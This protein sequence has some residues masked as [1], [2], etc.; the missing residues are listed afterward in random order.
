V[1]RPPHWGGYLVAP[2]EIEFWQ[3]RANRLHDRFAYTR[4]R[5][6]G[7]AWRRARLQP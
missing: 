3:G 6:D 5:A 7:G 4:E 1:P 2:R